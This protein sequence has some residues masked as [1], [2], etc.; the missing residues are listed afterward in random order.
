MVP[1]VPV[2]VVATVAVVVVATV[3][4]VVVATVTVLVGGDRRRPDALGGLARLG[5]AHAVAE[6]TRPRDL[7]HVVRA[8][9]R[10]VQPAT[11]GLTWRAASVVV[12]GMMTS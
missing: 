7:A 11:A 9:A 10:R 4:V 8:A 12:S 6:L 1:S 3:A 2:V 5:G